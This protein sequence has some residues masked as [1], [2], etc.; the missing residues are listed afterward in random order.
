MMVNIGVMMSVIMVM[1]VVV[2]MPVMVIM[3]VMMPMGVIAVGADAADMQ[4]VAGLD[5]ADIGFVADDL[6]AVLAQAAIHDVVAGRDLADALE[7]AS[8]TSGWSLR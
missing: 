3:P 1:P 7:E 8:M 5:C 4:V 6:G 2:P